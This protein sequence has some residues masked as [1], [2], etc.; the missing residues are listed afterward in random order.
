MPNK[1]SLSIRAVLGLVIGTM[2]LLLLIECSSALIE[3]VG[4]DVAAHRV[5]TL[6]SASRNLF[7]TLM[8][9]RLE[10]GIQISGLASE[11]KIDSASDS[12]LQAYRRNS[13][14]G[15]AESMTALQS[16]DVA[17][18]PAVV[19]ALRAAHDSVSSL[20]PKADSAIHQDRTGRDTALVQDYPKTTQAM[21]DAVLATSDLLEA[22]MKL[23]DPVVDQ[24]LSI[25][26][27]AWTTRLYLGSASVRTQTAV[28]AG[29]GWDQS[30]LTGW[31][32]DRARASLSWKQ[33]QEAGTRSDT[34][35]ILVDGIAKGN[36]N[37]SGPYFDNLKSLTEKLVAGEPP[38]VAINDLRKSDT[39]SNAYVVDVVNLALDQMVARADSQANRAMRNL[40]VDSLLLAAALALACFGF[41]IVVRR[42]SSPILSL[43]TLIG[44]L[45]EQ[46]YSV[47]IP[48]GTRAHEIGRMSQALIV[49][50][51]N[52]R[53]AKAEELARAEEQK[54]RER[55]A[56]A[57][58]ALCRQFDGR[59]GGN[60]ASV[61]KAV[62][63]LEQAS[64]SMSDTAEHSSETSASV[65]AAAHEASTSVSTVAAATEEL[66]SSVA[67]IGRQMT[68][69]TQ[70]SAEAI[71]KAA[72]TDQS[73]SGLATASQK[74]GEIIVMI[75]DIASQ[76]N[77]LALNA[78]IEAARAGEAGK[79]FAVVASEV[80][81]LANQTA[82]ATEEISQQI[83]QIQSMTEEAVGGVH[84][85]SDVIREMGSITTGIAA[86]IEEQGAATSEIARNVH[87]VADAANRITS[88]M[89][90]VSEAVSQSRM[91]AGEVRMSAESMKKQSA[92]LKSEVAGFLE[93]VRT[94]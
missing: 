20:R 76:T 17:G 56:A 49:L 65:A 25:K 86:A 55:R 53:R 26:R 22:S 8:G 70:I 39:D 89:G 6:A 24:F 88:L 93:G 41:L 34:P 7:K 4:R 43:T 18:L 63:Q 33:V 23:S 45:A 13:E 90:N 38:G 44:R 30:D 5:A 35:K 57:L 12:D 50:R 16:I 67:E 46:D 52:G 54:E 3:S 15:Y 87:E 71:T 48:T 19:T 66:S 79:G 68:Q 83:A 74:I 14:E 78:T 51:E 1:G 81:S 40:I 69:S 59:V 29:K 42:V 91:V 31:R 9:L 72:E 77:L 2:G 64:A 11:G 47:D 73:I 84:A 80:K 75:H 58:D 21:L 82:K 28:A 37:F 61:E 62:T 60:L 10:R 27:A 94:A 32:E 85:M 36:N 92:D